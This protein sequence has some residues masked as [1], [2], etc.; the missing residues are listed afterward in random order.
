MVMMPRSLRDSL[1]ALLV[2]DADKWWVSLKEDD[3]AELVRL[4]DSRKEIFLFET[5]D[6]SND[7]AKI[8]GGKFLPHDDGL[9]LQEWGEDWF[10]SLSS[11][12]ELMI[13]Y[14]PQVRTFHV[15]C[16]RHT[17]ARNCFRHGRINGD[18]QCPLLDATCLMDQIRKNRVTVELRLI[19]AIHNCNELSNPPKSAGNR[20]FQS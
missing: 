4:C 5:F 15:G 3:R 14:D 19:K 10:D 12:P 13:V 16:N 2:A 7:N 6:P 1:P 17:L 18:F 11:N 8:S 9:G 20:D